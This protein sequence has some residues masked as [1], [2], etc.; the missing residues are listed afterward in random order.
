MQRVTKKIT[1]TM[2]IYVVAVSPALDVHTPQCGQTACQGFPHFLAESCTALDCETS[3]R[4]K[5]Q[6]PSILNLRKSTESSPRVGCAGTSAGRIRGL[7]H[8]HYYLA[9]AHCHHG[10]NRNVPRCK[11]A[12]HS[13]SSGVLLSV[14]N[15]RGCKA[16]NNTLQ[17]SRNHPV[18]LARGVNPSTCTLQLEHTFLVYFELHTAAFQ[19]AVGSQRLSAAAG[20]RM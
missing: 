9:P 14:A 10:D 20:P 11:D 13:Q 16:P 5:R 7:P 3:R 18:S 17:D 2:H 15:L 1:V 8:L 12:H 6:E 4:C 19:N